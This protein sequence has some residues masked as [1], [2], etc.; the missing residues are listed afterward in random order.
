MPSFSY[1]IDTFFALTLSAIATGLT[2]NWVES[3]Q[4]HDPD[5]A[6]IPKK[7]IAFR[8][9]FVSGVLWLLCWASNV[10]VWIVLV[11]FA[12]IAFL[13]MLLGSGDGFLPGRVIVAGLLQFVMGFPMRRDLF[14]LPAEQAPFKSRVEKPHAELIGHEGIVKTPL[15]PVGRVSVDGALFEARSEQGDFIGIDQRVHVLRIEYEQLVVSM[16]SDSAS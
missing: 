3:H 16:V 13:P 11:V 7:Q 5:L 6:R 9:L 14:L 1:I 8:W 4:E 10:A 15:K 12:A 2:L